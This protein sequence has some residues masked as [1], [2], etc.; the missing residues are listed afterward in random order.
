MLDRLL[1]LLSA[2]PAARE[3]PSEQ[4][5][6]A[7]LLMELG[8]ADFDF[9]EVEERRIREL[10][11]RRY[12][13]DAAQL[14]GLM[15]QAQGAGRNAVSL[16][17]YTRAINERFDHAGKYELMEMLWQVAWADGRL[18]PNEEYLLRKL[19][20]LLNIPEPDYIRAKLAV[21][22]ERGIS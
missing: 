20:G 10:L 6:V 16:Y 7:L 2:G 9:A 15:A 3:Q 11:A 8:R 17:D 14:D 1:G 19:A 13:L 18:D 12:Q 5:S 22:Q 4:L 21:M